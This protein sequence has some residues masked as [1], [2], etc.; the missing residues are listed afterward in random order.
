VEPQG[1]TADILVNSSWQNGK[2]VL[3]L[4]RKLDTGN[5]DDK[6]FEVGKVYYISLAVF[7]DMVSNRRHHVSFPLTLGIGVDA[8][9]KAL[10]AE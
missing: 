6:A 3:E 10:R 9:I 1:S 2:W 4:R 7:D 8:D 5:P